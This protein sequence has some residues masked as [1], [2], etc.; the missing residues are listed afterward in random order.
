MLHSGLFISFCHCGVESKKTESA[1]MN[2]RK[3]I[4]AILAALSASLA[5]AE[6]FKTINGKEYKNATVSHVEPDGLVLKTKSG[7]SKVYF[8]ELPK[9]VQERY[10]YNAEKAAAYSAEQTANAAAF[11][12][13]QQ[14]AEALQKQAQQQSRDNTTTVELKYES[15]EE[16]TAAAHKEAREKMFSTEEENALLTKIPPGGEL[17]VGLHGITIGVANPKLLTFIIYNPKGEVLERHSGHSS[18]PSA[19]SEYNWM[20]IDGVNLPAFDDSLRVRVY[21]QLSGNLGDYV[22]HR[23]GQPTRLQ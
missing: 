18:V 14:Q 7:I 19:I 3:T 17:I 16:L 11:S 23:N 9:E 8:A 20:G 13:Q 12:K 10:N 21:H 4:I 15:P 22:I 6:D 1:H 5:L 2:P